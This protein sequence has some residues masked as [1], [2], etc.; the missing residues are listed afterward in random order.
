[1]SRTCATPPGRLNE[2]YFARSPSCH[3]SAAVAVARIDQAHRPTSVNHGLLPA[4]EPLPLTTPIP[5]GLTK[6]ATA[7]PHPTPIRSP[8]KACC[9]GTVSSTSESARESKVKAGNTCDQVRSRPTVVRS[10]GSTQGRTMQVDGKLSSPQGDEVV[11]RRKIGLK[12]SSAVVGGV[13]WTPGE[14][15]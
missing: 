12:G 8:E 14:R 5:S 4:V 15:C 10:T 7:T 2:R 9:V 3:G 1:M 11:R 13:P 6:I